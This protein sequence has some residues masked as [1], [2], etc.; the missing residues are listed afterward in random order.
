MSETNAELWQIQFKSSK[1]QKGWQELL[2]AAPENMARCQERL[3]TNPLERIPGRVYP[4]KGKSY[5]GAWEYEVTGADR[6]L[7]LPDLSTKIVLIFYAG[8]HPKPPYPQPPNL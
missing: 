3:S 6:V 1:V 2:E 5:K 7:Y 8:K 4:M